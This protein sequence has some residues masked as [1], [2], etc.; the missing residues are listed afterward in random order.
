MKKILTVKI[1]IIS[2]ITLQS[3]A[4]ALDFQL[5]VGALDISKSD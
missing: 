4:W 5:G 3:N 2:L 1:F